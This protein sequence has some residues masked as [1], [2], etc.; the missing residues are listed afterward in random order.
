MAEKFPIPRSHPG[1]V[2]K[3]W[4]RPLRAFSD[5]RPD[6]AWFVDHHPEYEPL[7][8]LHD[9]VTAASGS[10]L[11]GSAIMGGGFVA[12]TRPD[13]AHDEGVL[14][15]RFDARKKQF[16]FDYRNADV[17]PPHSERCSVDVAWER[18]RLFLGY[19][20]GIQCPRK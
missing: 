13:V 2:T 20:F 5:S 19:K 12:A 11:Y 14:V 3:R 8:D 16:T 18:L 6:V 7:L 9:R 17:E 4:A 10:S 15:V 1:R